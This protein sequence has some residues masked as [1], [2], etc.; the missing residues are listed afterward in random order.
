[1]GWHH[2][3]TR[4]LSNPASYRSLPP[5]SQLKIALLTLLLLITVFGFFASFSLVIFLTPRPELERWTPEGIKCATC[6]ELMSQNWEVGK[7]LGC[8]G[9]DRDIVSHIHLRGGWM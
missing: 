1:M 5:T 2:S 4:N 7:V 3:S 6:E 9:W 8:V